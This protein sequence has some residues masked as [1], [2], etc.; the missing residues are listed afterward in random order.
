MERMVLIVAAALILGE[1][2]FFL[3]RNERETK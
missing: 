2:A 1:A 3:V